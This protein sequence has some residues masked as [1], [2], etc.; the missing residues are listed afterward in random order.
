[1]KN[2]KINKAITLVEALPYIK[3]FSGQIMVIK[4]GGSL[5][6][7][8]SLRETLVTLCWD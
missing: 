4:Y 5:M 6:V 8:E 2:D 1:M 3:Q 7:N